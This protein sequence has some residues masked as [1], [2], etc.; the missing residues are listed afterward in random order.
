MS[1]L[2]IKSY[3]TD[4]KIDLTNEH[5][6]LVDRYGYMNASEINDFNIGPYCKDN[7]CMI[8]FGVTLGIDNF[9]ATVW[10]GTKRDT[11]TAIDISFNASAW[12]QVKD[13]LG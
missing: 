2:E 9:P 7:G 5:R 13:S 10:V 12:D 3:K 6:D 8:P 4:P 1:A 11:V